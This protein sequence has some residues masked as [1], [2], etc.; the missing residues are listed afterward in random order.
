MAMI[1]ALA[2]PLILYGL[3]VQGPLCLTLENTL[4]IS[5]SV[6]QSGI[7]NAYAHTNSTQMLAP[8]RCAASSRLKYEPLSGMVSNPG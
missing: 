2:I 1:V 6:Q 3:K 5:H 7:N 8:C 4:S